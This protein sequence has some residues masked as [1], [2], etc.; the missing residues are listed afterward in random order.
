MPRPAASGLGAEFALWLSPRITANVDRLLSDLFKWAQ[1]QVD[2]YLEAVVR[3]AD[4]SG[5]GALAEVP[6]TVHD[7]SDHEDNLILD[8]AAEVGALILL[9]SDS[10]LLSMSPRRGTP[11]IEP[12]VF[13]SKVDATRRHARRRR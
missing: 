12:N 3:A 11:I 13:A 2:G 7:C 10:D 6:R 8:L 4:Q 5:G 1:P 9:S